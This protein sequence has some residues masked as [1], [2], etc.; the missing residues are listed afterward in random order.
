MSWPA[1][2]PPPQGAARTPP[3]R[4]FP[5]SPSR[6]RPGR[7]K[8]FHGNRGGQ[9][10]RLR[11]RLCVPHARGEQ[12]PGEGQRHQRDGPVPPVVRHLGGL[13]RGQDPP[14][15]QR[16]RGRAQVDGAIDDAHRDARVLLAPKVHARR[17]GEHPVHANDTQGHED[18]RPSQ[19]HAVDEKEAGHG[20]HAHARVEHRGDGPPSR[21]KEPV[22]DDA[23]EHA[24]G[25]ARHAQQHAPVGGDER[26][27]D[28]GRLRELGVPLHDGVAH[29]ATAELDE[30]DDNDRGVAHHPR[31]HGDQ[32]QPRAGIARG[33]IRGV[34]V[35]VPGIARRVP[36]DEEV[37][38]HEGQQ[39]GGR[40]EEH[41][42]GGRR[43]DD[44]R[45]P[46]VGEVHA[47]RDEDAE[48]PAQQPPLPDVEPGRVHLDDGDGAKALEVHVGRVEDRQRR[49][50]PSRRLPVLG[51]HGVHHRAHQHV[52]H[53]GAR[54][55]QQDRLAASQPVRQRAVEQERHAIDDGSPEEDGAKVRVRR[56]AAHRAGGDV[57]VVAPHIEERV[58]HPQGEPVE[59]P[60]ALERL[61]VPQLHLGQ[62]REDQANRREQDENRQQLLQPL[63][64]GRHA[65]N[66]GGRREPPRT[67]PGPLLPA[68]PAA[69]LRLPGQQPGDGDL[70]LRVRDFSAAARVEQRLDG[71]PAQLRA[72]LQ[73]RAIPLRRLGLL[74]CHVHRRR[75]HLLRQN[76]RGHEEAGAQK[77]DLLG[78]HHV[79]RLLAHLLRRAVP[80]PLLALVLE[81]QQPRDDLLHA[82]V[83]A[84]VRHRHVLALAEKGRGPEVHPREHLQPPL[85]PPVEEHRHRVQA[86]PVH[87]IDPVHLGSRSIR[88]PVLAAQPPH[89]QKTLVAP[90]RRR[91]IL[92]D[93]DISDRRV[94]RPHACSVGGKPS[95]GR[96][97]PESV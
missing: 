80:Q 35:R 81:F 29:V 10:R 54:R 25:D 5:E 87:H 78:P 74:A 58:R 85:A 97:L 63:G 42:V 76:A 6:A 43:F 30:Q 47:Q 20:P 64:H 45:A 61:G 50:E 67:L 82:Q 46:V 28:A 21:I 14:E 89:A 36:D 33:G 91:E 13:P 88:A 49:H 75:K 22:G 26:S 23:R 34:E 4:A 3:L 8:R 69:W 90:R 2:G 27:A 71:M 37:Q 92:D 31:E 96:C 57:H 7:G 19:H 60:A 72:L 38:H 62:A 9:G 84:P 59:E 70:R 51:Q 93:L 94:V 11:L 77:A 86:G 79:A 56:P 73:G 17:A 68:N 40:H 48:H 16:L 32:S 83:A 24:S 66:L 39:N 55:R 44:H 1:N 15:Q 65:V 41:P 52:A 18:D 95:S 53:R 12:Q